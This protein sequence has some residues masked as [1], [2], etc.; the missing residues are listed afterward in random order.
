MKTLTSSIL[1]LLLVSTLALAEQAERPGLPQEQKGSV[2]NGL[3]WTIKMANEFTTLDAM[4]ISCSL[5]NTSNELFTFERDPKPGKPT[6]ILT[7]KGKDPI[8]AAL[9]QIKGSWNESGNY[10][11]K[12][13]EVAHGFTVDIRLLFGFLPEG[14]YSLQ[15]VY[16]KDAYSLKDYPPYK[17]QDIPSP[18]RPFV[19][20]TTSLA[21]AQ[22]SLPKDVGVTLKSDKPIVVDKRSRVVETGVLENNT[23]AP[24]SFSAYTWEQKEDRPLSAIV[25]WEKWNTRFQWTLLGP[26]GWCGTGL[27]IFTLQPKQSVCVHLNGGLQDGIYRFAIDYWSA[28]DPKNRKTVY[29][30]AIQISNFADVHLKDEEI[31]PRNPGDKK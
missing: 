21:D 10:Q 20:Y 16:P 22:E 11:P 27:G 12:P 14:E 29:S 23:D 7:P 28:D 31:K 5:D 13:G 17:S 8:T 24:I 2:V 15:V 30:N 9:E 1:S 26:P 3:T 4:E 6:L 18:R 25:T 19:V